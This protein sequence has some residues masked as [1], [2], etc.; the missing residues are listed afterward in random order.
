MDSNMDLKKLE[1][2]LA[3]IYSEN[4]S[5]RY[6]L[7]TCDSPLSKSTMDKFKKVFDKFK[8]EEE[9]KLKETYIIT[10]TKFKKMLLKTYVSIFNSNNNIKIISD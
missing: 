4:D 1:E 10:D 3:E 2:R 8:K 9:E 5:I 7:D 6:I